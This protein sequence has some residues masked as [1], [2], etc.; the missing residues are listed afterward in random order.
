MKNKIPGMDKLSLVVL[1][2]GQGNTL[3]AIIEQIATQ[4]LNADIRA[5]IS[6]N[7]TA[8]GLQRANNAH[9][10][11]HIINHRA[12]HDRSQ[13]DMA[14]KDII[15]LYQPDIIVLAGFMR[16]L[17]GEFINAF[18]HKIVNVHPSL[19]PVYKGLNTH[20]RA[21]ADQAKEHGCSIHFVTEALDGGPVI[22]QAR[23]AILDTDDAQTLAQ[24][25]QAKERI[26]YPMVLQWLTDNTLKYEGATIFF[27]EVPLKA[28]LILD[29][30]VAKA[31]Q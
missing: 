4:K 26:I 13:Y 31:D 30:T 6:N 7:P 5:V 9:I 28:P 25:V 24:R 15:S 11:T 22:L 21:L 29:E 18:Q 16:I 1:I 12:Y 23:V 14:L 19:L 27:K 20:Q 8:Y 2:S 10:K 3:Q 17:S